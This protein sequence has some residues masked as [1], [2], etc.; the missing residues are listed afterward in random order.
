M[1]ATGVSIYIPTKGRAD[2]RLTNKALT[3]LGVPHFLIVEPQEVDLY[4]RSAH[5]TT[6]TVLPLDMSF[7]T[8]YELCDDL[9]L[10]K[11]TGPGP[12]RNF[13]WEHAIASGAKWHWVMDDNIASFFCFHQHAR[14]GRHTDAG[15]MAWCL[16]FVER[17]ENIGMFGPEY[18]FFIPR[19]Q[20]H[21]AWVWPTRVYSCNLIRNDVP[22]RW[23]GRYNEDTILSLDM[24][25]AGYV[26][27]TWRCI[28]QKKVATQTLGGGNTAD[29]YA[30][31]GTRPKSEMLARVYPQFARV[32]ER[33]DRVHHVVDY[34]RAATRQPILKHGVSAPVPYV[35]ESHNGPT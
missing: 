2:S 27:G 10:T 3:K 17:Y 9:G 12:A 11:S 31:E 26:C 14:I 21:Y 24:L 18:D 33:W 30:K 13:A 35:P 5:G 19:Y 25:Q 32:V 29:F 4:R 8:R 16:D 15:W 34:R 22:L 7:K 20:K 23:R 1:A 28:A 6:G